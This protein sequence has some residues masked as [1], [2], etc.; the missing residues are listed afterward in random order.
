MHVPRPGNPMRRQRR[1]TP[2]GNRHAPP[3]AMLQEPWQERRP[4]D[5]PSPRAG[6]RPVRV[7]PRPLPRVCP[8]A[9]GSRGVPRP[10]SPCSLLHPCRRQATAIQPKLQKLSV[11]TGG[12][13][14]TVLCWRSVAFDGSS[15]EGSCGA[16]AGEAVSGERD[17][18][19]SRERAGF[20]VRLRGEAICSMSHF[21]SEWVNA[22]PPFP[23]RPGSPVPPRVARSSS[24][25]P[26][27]ECRGPTSASSRAVGKAP[28]RKMAPGVWLQGP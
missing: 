27:S 23:G 17:S 13:R 15:V 7:A 10:A 9:H 14:R 8:P 16:G 3:R 28:P 2:G 1:R 5:A 26:R 12:G 25:R 4:R 6:S 18:P 19:A 21:R 11:A 20:T 24:R 22:R